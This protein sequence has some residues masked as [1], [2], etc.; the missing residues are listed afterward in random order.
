M[1]P[2]VEGNAD[3]QIS[4]T[5][6][7]LAFYDPVYTPIKGFDPGP[8]WDLFPGGRGPISALFRNSGPVAGGHKCFA[9]E[10]VVVIV[11]VPGVSR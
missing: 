4:K 9:S 6:R 8:L 3:Y 10:T 1:R 5:V 2:K 11:L 7:L